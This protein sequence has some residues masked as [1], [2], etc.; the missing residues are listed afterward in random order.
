M[1]AGA[2][3]FADPFLTDFLALGTGSP[4]LSW[5]MRAAVACA[6]FGPLAA[7]GSIA[8][9]GAGAAGTLLAGIVAAVAVAAACIGLLRRDARDASGVHQLAQALLAS[10][11]DCL[12]VLS[13]QGRL[14]HMSETGMRLMEVCDFAPLAGADWMSFWR[15]MPKPPAA[16]RSS[17][18]KAARR[19]RSWACA[20]PWQARRSGGPCG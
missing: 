14:L 9:F 3:T 12:K 8:V 20:R 2:P 10:N 1:P 19:A 11:T 15:P 5:R 4:C 7:A 18:S 17:G 6:A 16:P 13:P